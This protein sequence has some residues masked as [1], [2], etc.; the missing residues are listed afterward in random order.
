MRIRNLKYIEEHP[1]EFKDIIRNKKLS[2]P[3]PKAINTEY[4]GHLF[5]SRLEAKW[6]IFF[7]E[8]GVRWE[9]EKEGFENNGIKYLPDFYFTDYDIWVEIKPINHNFKD[10]YKWIMFTEK[11]NLLLLQDI[12]NIRPTKYYGKGGIEYDIIPF[13]DKIKESYG[14]L[15]YSGGDEDW[16]DVE[17]FTT[18]IRKANQYRF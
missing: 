8:I 6:A 14:F 15:W 17:P 2:N 7:D 12:P 5:R 11:Y 4:K 3:L 16:S 1:E 13:A 18:A 10:I 9:Y